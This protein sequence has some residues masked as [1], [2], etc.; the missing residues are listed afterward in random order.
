MDNYSDVVARIAND[1]MDRVK[2]QLRSVPPGEQDEFLKEIRS[3][4]YE[5][6]QQ[7]PGE[8]DVA[9][10][11]VVLR[12]FGEPADVVADR[13]P[14]KLVRSGAQRNVPLYVIGGIFIALFGL[15]LGAGAVGVLIGLLGALAGIVVAYFASVGS[16]LLVGALFM[17]LGLVRWFLPHAWDQLVT[18]GI[19]RFNDTPGDFFDNLP[20]AEQGL[21][22]IVVAS[23]LIAAGLGGLW[24]GKRLLVGMRFLLTL[25]FDWL[26]RLAQGAR[27][28]LRGGE[29]PHAK[30][31]RVHPTT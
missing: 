3:H 10:I 8:D 22:L 21:L 31:Q 2:A 11:L 25:A 13:L 27:R 26:R 28:S 18:I 7:T 1:Y 6:Y 9:R 19:I 5:A 15:P 16:V 29:Q 12:N 20:P 17:L 14:G 23:V 24:L 30:A 4:L